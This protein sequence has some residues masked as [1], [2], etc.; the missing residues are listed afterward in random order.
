[1]S[2]YLPPSLD[3]GAG[4]R[5]YLKDQER[6]KAADEM[7]RE[8]VGSSEIKKFLDGADSSALRGE[9]AAAAARFEKTCRVYGW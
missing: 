1:M 2:F 8:G 6:R 3:G 7:R 4:A 5:T 9:A